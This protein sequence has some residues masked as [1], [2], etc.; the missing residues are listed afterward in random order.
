MTDPT[1]ATVV[2]QVKE[3]TYTEYKQLHWRLRDEY[4]NIP[5]TTAISVDDL[6]PPLFESVMAFGVRSRENVM[7]QW[8]E[9]R[10]W[11]GCNYGAD[12]TQTSWHWLTPCDG[13]IEGVTHWYKIPSFPKTVRADP[14]PGDA[15]GGGQG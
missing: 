13:L 6:L 10:R 4:D 11:T 14:L 1:P 8:Y 7:R 12:K 15:A 2:G 5:E 3:L 9:A